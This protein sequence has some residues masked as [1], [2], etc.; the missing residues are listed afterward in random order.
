MAPFLQLPCTTA[1]GLEWPAR[2]RARIAAWTAGL[3]L[4]KLLHPAHRATMHTRPIPCSG[5]PLPIVGCGT[6]VG[7]DVK[8]DGTE[9][10]QR[11]AVL[12]ALFAAGGTVIDSSP[13]YG[14]AEASVGA[15]LPRHADARPFV[16]TKVWTRG[17]DAGLAQMQR[18]IELLRVPVIDLMQVHNLVDWRVHLETLR[19]WKATGRI[20]YLGVTHYTA[21]AHAELEAVLQAELVDFV[22]FN[23]SVADRH[24]EQRLLPLASE[25]GIAVLAN[26]PL[27]SGGVLRP[28]RRVPLPPVAAELACT[29]WAQLLLKFVLGHTAVTCAIPGTGD[30]VHM[31]D[32]AAAGQ[33]PLP[34]ERQR[35]LI[36]RA[37]TGHAA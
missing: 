23:Y 35:A 32:N 15:L 5:E 24:A 16:A 36:L 2:R 27:G 26:L 33:G 11:S 30:P 34:D 17:R 14:R 4:V 6:Y 12:G 18:S 20:R 28:V 1:A 37:W 7:F 8:P 29:S 31:A 21:S 3:T 9:G 22:Q 19:E 25:R 13:M 10:V